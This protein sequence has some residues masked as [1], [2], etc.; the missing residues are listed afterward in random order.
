MRETADCLTNLTGADLSHMFVE[1]SLTAVDRVYI[2]RP[3]DGILQLRLPW[4]NYG[5]K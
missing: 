3:C 1:T 5:A 2:Q 4:K